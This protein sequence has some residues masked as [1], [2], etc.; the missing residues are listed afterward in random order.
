MKTIHD[1]LDSLFLNVPITPETRKAKED[2]SAIMED[3]YHELISQGKSEHEAIGAVIS[4]FGSVD[5]LLQA[6]DISSEASQEDEDWEDALSEEESF[7]YW[8]TVRYFALYVSTG[9][10]L[11][12]ASLAIMSFLLGQGSGALGVLMMLVFGALGVGFILSA[13]LKYAASRKKMDDRFI[14]KTIKHIAR[15]QLEDYEKSFRIGLVLGIGLCIFSLAPVLMSS[16]F[17]YDMP[18]GVALFLL[19]VAVGVFFIVY[20]S[21]IR[22]GYAKLVNETYFIRD[23]D[24]PGTRA[25]KHKY[26][27]AAGKVVFFHTV[28]WP[29][30]LVV[31]FM[32]SFVFHAWACSWLIFVVGG[33]LQDFFL[34]QVNRK[35]N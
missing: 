23:E 29:V 30:I 27:D 31:Y 24:H 33:I 34:A 17:Y 9:I 4:E 25:T 16:I 10:G 5:E 3:H 26:G 1:Y 35:R 22:S 15:Q 18:F 21:V 14:S 20:V 13:A 19:M 32:W 11:C 7:D 2:L 12:I 8:Q 6:L 28:Y